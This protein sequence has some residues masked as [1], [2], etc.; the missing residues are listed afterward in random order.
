VSGNHF[1]YTCTSSYC[2][3][4]PVTLIDFLGS[5]NTCYRYVRLELA[6]SV[7]P[8]QS[9]REFSS[10]SYVTFGLHSSLKS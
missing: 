5:F 4:T 8:D 6:S 7:L 2:A 9:V 3:V 1:S 10:D